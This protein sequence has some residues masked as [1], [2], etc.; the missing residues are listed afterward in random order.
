MR[1]LRRLR[2]LSCGNK[3]GRSWLPRS[4]DRNTPNLSRLIAWF[5][6]RRLSFA[7]V[8]IFARHLDL[9]TGVFQT[10]AS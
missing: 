3:R 5:V 9:S 2:Q 6:E 10:D 4:Q 1:A 7:F 8:S